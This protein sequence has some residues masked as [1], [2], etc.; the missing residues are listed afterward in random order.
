MRAC[1]F[2]GH[3]L[4]EHLEVFRSTA[5]P[6]CGKELKVCLNCRFHRPGAHWDC[7]ETIQ[8]PV[9]E[10]GRANF[11]EYFQ[12]RVTA[13]AAVREPGRAGGVGAKQPRGPQRGPKTPESARDSFQKL[14]G[15]AG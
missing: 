11:C 14:F 5:C 15:D 6:G 8:E 12:F 7:L 9:A 10:K 1:T 13:A 2:C 3:V 4:D